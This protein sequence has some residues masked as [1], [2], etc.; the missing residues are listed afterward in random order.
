M[1][2]VTDLVELVEPIAV[3]LKLRE[4]ADSV[5]GAVPVPVRVTVCGLLI[6]LSAMLRVPVAAPN[7]T[8]VK[9]TPTRQFAPA[10]MLIPQV[11]LAMA[12]GLPVDMEM[13]V[14]VSAVLSLL[15]TVTVFTAL[16]LATASEP[17]LRLLEET[18]TGALPLPV[19][20][21]VC[22]PALSVMVRTPEAEPTTVGEKMIEIVHDAAGAMLPLQVLVWLNG[23]VTATF[24]TWSGPVPELSTVTFFAVLEVPMTSEEKESD[25]GVMV[26]AGD[27]PVPFSTSVC[28]APWL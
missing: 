7:A 28:K 5:T 14:S 16:V 19:T 26:A 22:V 17:K 8:G 2:S 27:V 18:V 9:V 20:A 24:V 15:V 4:P 6:A 21:T 23:P 12:K 25:V 11:L 13:P 3:V 1:V 10:A